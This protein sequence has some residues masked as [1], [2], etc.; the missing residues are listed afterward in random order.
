MFFDEGVWLFWSIIFSGIFSIWKG[1]STEVGVINA[2][3]AAAAGVGAAGIKAALDAKSLVSAISKSA[4]LA[5]TAIAQITA[6]SNGRI[7]SNN[8]FAAEGGSVG[9]GVGATPALMDS[10]PYSYSRTI[11][12]TEEEERLNAPIFVT[13]TDIEEGLAH[14]ATVTDESS[15]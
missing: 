11:Q 12:T 1:Y 7:V 5:G 4:S 14:R 10:T 8:N 6:A 15:F 13:V 9:G 2:Q 3:T